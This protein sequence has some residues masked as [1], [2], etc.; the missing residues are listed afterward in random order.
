M[1]PTDS[2]YKITGF[3]SPCS[4]YHEKI[5]SLDE[6]YHINHPGIFIVE[7]SGASPKLGIQS[8]DKLIINRAL[9]PTRGQLVLLVLDN[10]FKL[11]H[12][13][14]ELLKGKDPETEDFLWGVVTT[15]LREFK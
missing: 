8:G 10:E 11:A 6:R 3:Q 7:A 14:P 15:L 9:K 13:V 4:E 5:L 2:S 12:F 1:E